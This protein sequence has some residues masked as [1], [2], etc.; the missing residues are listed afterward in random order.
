MAS[1]YTVI[2]VSV[3]SSGSLATR[4]E[5]LGFSERFCKKKKKKYQNPRSLHQRKNMTMKNFPAGLVVNVELQY[6][7]HITASG[8]AFYICMHI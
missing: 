5:H 3:L 8:H 7:F 6:Y 4:S 2:T 1:P